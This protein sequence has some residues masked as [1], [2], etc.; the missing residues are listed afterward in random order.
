MVLTTWVGCGCGFVIK[1]KEEKEWTTWVVRRGYVVK[2][3][4]DTRGH[5]KKRVERG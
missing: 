5:R 1:R 3:L 2:I 4:N